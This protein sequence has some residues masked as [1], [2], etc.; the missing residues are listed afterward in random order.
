MCVLYGMFVLAARVTTRSS[1]P[2]CNDYLF[3]RCDA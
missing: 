2:I 3:T 1:E